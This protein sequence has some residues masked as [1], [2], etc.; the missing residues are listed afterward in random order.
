MADSLPGQYGLSIGYQQM[1]S[2]SSATAP[3]VPAGSLYALVQAEAVDCR[4]RDDGT[5]PSG[6]VGMLLSAGAPQGF[7]GGQLST[8]Q[9]IQT[10]GGTAKINIEYYG[11][12]HI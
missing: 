4:W 7:T 8:V 2:L 11:A 1:T 3:T 6:T 10:S 5:A 9:F 12:W